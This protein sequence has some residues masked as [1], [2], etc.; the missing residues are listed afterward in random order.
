MSEK[1]ILFSAPMVKAIIDGRKSQTRRVVKPQPQTV[2]DVYD[3]P[4]DAAN[5]IEFYQRA[6]LKCPHPVGARLWV[7]ETHLIE[8]PPNLKYDAEG[9]PVSQWP[10]YLETASTV[11]YKADKA[12]SEFW[13]QFK[14]RP[15][16]FMPRWASR[17]TLTVKEVRVQRLQEISDDDCRAEGVFGYPA[18]YYKGCWQSEYSQLWDSI[19]GGKI[20]S[21]WQD[22]P[23]V[24]A[25]TFE[26]V[27]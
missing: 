21:S 4:S 20:G 14:W 2:G 23:W 3:G 15:S 16:I 26:V 8:L 9:L 10:A 11:H 25:Y 18:G 6:R 17:I 22:N 19:N 5:S 7:K 24:W 27:K 1:P 12:D 13:S